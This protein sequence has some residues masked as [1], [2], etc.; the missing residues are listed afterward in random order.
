MLVV[1]GPHDGM[2][3]SAETERYSWQLMVQDF[4]TT[5]DDWRVRGLNSTLC[6]ETYHPT[7]F[8]ANGDVYWIL[9]HHRLNAS[10]VMRE[11]MRE[12]RRR[13]RD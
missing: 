3:V 11:L 9:R 8:H 13:P 7:Q 1:G 10:Q 2:T 4:P 6:S 5:S 12:Y